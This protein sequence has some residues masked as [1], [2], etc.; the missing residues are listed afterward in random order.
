VWT[1]LWGKIRPP[2]LLRG[3][4]SE[5]SGH[6]SKL[7]QDPSQFCLRSEL[8][9]WHSALSWSCATLPPR[10][11][12]SPRSADTPV[13][14]SNTTTSVTTPGPRG[15]PYPSPH[16]RGIRTPEPRNSLRWDPSGFPLH[17]WADLGPQDS[18]SKFLLEWT[19]L[20]GVLTNRIVGCCHSQR[21]QDQLKPEITRLRVLLGIGAKERT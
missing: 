21:Q 14:T 17:P 20:P 4:I 2:L 5:P 19:D 10:E 6:R 7:G 3:T 18:I 15:T 11:S 9:L 8:T 1:S 13:S 16:P 12:W